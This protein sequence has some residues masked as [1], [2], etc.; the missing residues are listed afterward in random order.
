[1][2]LT[3]SANLNAKDYIPGNRTNLNPHKKGVKF[4][5]VK[6]EKLW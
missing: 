5:H 4:H 2:K 1:M 6:R 3:Y